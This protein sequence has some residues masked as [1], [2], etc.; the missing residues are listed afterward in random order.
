MDGGRPSKVVTAVLLGQALFRHRV[1]DDIAVSRT[2]FRLKRIFDKERFWDPAGL[3][4]Q[5]ICGALKMPEGDDI[6]MMVFPTSAAD[7]AWLSLGPQCHPSLLAAEGHL[8][9]RHVC[10]DEFYLSRFHDSARL[11]LA[12]GAEP[13]LPQRGRRGR[14]NCPYRRPSL[15]TSRPS[16]CS[17]ERGTPRLSTMETTRRAGGPSWRRTNAGR[18]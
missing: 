10:S 12:G 9:L 5:P 8:E 15:A 18:C 17:T 14:P 7:Q 6:V 11:A 1:A 16:V 3:R 2:V 13:P 4:S